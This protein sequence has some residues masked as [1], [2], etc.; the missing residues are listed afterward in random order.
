MREGNPVFDDLARGAAAAAD[1]LGGV[2]E[3]VEARVRDRVEVFAR[4][5]DLVTREE[6]EAASARTSELRG[7]VYDDFRPELED[8]CAAD[9]QQRISFVEGAG[10]VTGS[11]L[12]FECLQGGEEQV[13]EGVITVGDTCFRSEGASQRERDDFCLLATTAPNA[14]QGFN[15]PLTDQLPV[16]ARLFCEPVALTCEIACRND[17]NCPGGFVCVPADY[18]TGSPS[19]PDLSGVCINPTCSAN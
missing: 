3:E 19:D 12:G 16:N 15:Q 1:A 4:D 8:E 2:R 10:P 18:G 14:E 6:F 7:W 9:R 5:M 11:I 13:T 17:A